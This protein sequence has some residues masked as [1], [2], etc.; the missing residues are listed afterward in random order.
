MEDVP[1]FVEVRGCINCEASKSLKEKTGHDYGFHHELMFKCM[2]NCFDYG[3][4]L[5]RPFYDPEEIVRFAK[6][7][8]SKQNIEVSKK[9]LSKIKNAF[10]AHFYEEIGVSIDDLLTELE[11]IEVKNEVNY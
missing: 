8:P 4:D 1:Y 9:Y 3:R 2:Y 6:K 10:F 5:S 11:E 7:S